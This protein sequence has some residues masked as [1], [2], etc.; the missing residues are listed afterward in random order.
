MINLNVTSAAFTNGAVI[1]TR[2]TG[3]GEDVSPPLQW[4]GIPTNAKELALIVDDPD[5]PTANPWVH[6]VIYKIPATE[7]G[8]PEN[9]AKTTALLQP[10][11]TVQGRNSWGTTGY[12]GPAPPRGGGVHHYHFKLYALDKALPVGAGMDKN[13]LLNAISGHVL[14]QGELVGTYQR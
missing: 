14:A 10:V 8:L 9:V 5:A 2:F 3:D 6:W 13:Q 11:G 7:I 12:R 1:P 4:T